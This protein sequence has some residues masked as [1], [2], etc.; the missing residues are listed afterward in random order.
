MYLA[1]SVVSA[2][3]ELTSLS[4]SHLDNMCFPL[5]DFGVAAAEQQELSTNMS[6]QTFTGKQ[7]GHRPLSR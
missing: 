5:L 2:Y 6:H 1:L 4:E 7:T 3:L